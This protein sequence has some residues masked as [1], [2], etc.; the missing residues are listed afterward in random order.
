MLNYSKERHILWTIAIEKKDFFFIASI[1]TYSKG[2]GVN[3]FIICLFVFLSVIIHFDN[4]YS[5]SSHS[6]HRNI[7]Y[8]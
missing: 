2:G 3:Y 6:Y 8:I 4:L 5:A 7:Q 1:R